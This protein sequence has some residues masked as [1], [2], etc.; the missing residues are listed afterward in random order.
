LA[1]SLS[2]PVVSPEVNGQNKPDWTV[3]SFHVN[4]TNVLVHVRDPDLRAT[5]AARGAVCGLGRELAA[6]GCP[7]VRRRGRTGIASTQRIER[8]AVVVGQLRPNTLPAR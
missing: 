1:A 7:L 2:D 4:G 3:P 8:A 5:E 6:T